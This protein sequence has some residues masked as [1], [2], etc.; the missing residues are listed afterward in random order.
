MNDHRIQRTE[1]SKNS[2]LV[3]FHPLEMANPKSV[4]LSCS[5]SKKLLSSILD[6]STAPRMQS[7]HLRVFSRF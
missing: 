1:H 2:G 3:A 7:S 6:L 5:N 4:V